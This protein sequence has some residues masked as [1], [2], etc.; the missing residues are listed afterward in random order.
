MTYVIAGYTIILSLLFLY[1]VHLVWRRRWLTRAAERLEAAPAPAHSEP[2][3][4]GR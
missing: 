3:T 1:A 4:E 2:V